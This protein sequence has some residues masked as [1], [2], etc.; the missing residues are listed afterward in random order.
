MFDRTIINKSEKEYV[1][2]VK[3]EAKAPTDE[4]LRLLDEFKQTAIKSITDQLELKNEYCKG[5][6][7][8]YYDALRG[9]RYLNVRYTLNAHDYNFNI[10]ITKHKSREEMMYSLMDSLS[11]NIRQ[12][13]LDNVAKAIKDIR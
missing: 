10:T 7:T 5:M 4:S 3:T 9:E 6:V 11:F 13:L 1:P 8:Q 2:Y 12:Q